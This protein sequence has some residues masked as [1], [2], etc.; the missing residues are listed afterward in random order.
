[1]ALESD[2]YAVLGV[3]RDA[4][5]SQIAK[6]RRRLSRE[7]HPDVNSEPAAS[8]RFV[9]IQ[10]AFALLSDPAARAEYDRTGRLPGRGPGARGQEAA[11]GI[12]VEPASVDFGVLELGRPGTDAEVTVSWT[13][14]SPARIKSGSGND[15]WTTLR[16]A[17]PDAS[18]VVFFLRA[19]AV[20]G[21]AN[22][23]QRDQFTVT[24]DDTT[25]AVGLTAEIQGVPPPPPPPV[26]ETAGQVP[27]PRR[28]APARRR[29]SAGPAIL[30]LITLSFT[31]IWALII[32]QGGGSSGAPSAPTTPTVKPVKVPQ[33]RAPAL[34]VRPVFHDIA[35]D[36]DPL[37]GIVGAPVQHG[38]EILVPLFYSS[39][40]PQPSYCV[41][42]TV[43][44]TDPG[45]DEGLT[46]MESPVGTVTVRGTKELAY[47]AVIPGTYALDAYCDPYDN[48]P[49][50]LVLGFAATPDL[51]VVSGFL[52]NAMVV[53]DAHTTGDVTTVTYGVVGGND[54]GTL[55]PPADDACIDGG[56]A[57]DIATYWQPVRD[58]V[59]QQVNG[60]QEWFSTGS[61]V[62]RD[63]Q[64]PGPQGRFYY[65]CAQDTSEYPLG[66]MVP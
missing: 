18:C 1:M 63:R 54:Y 5:A 45:P 59:S 31:L 39:P 48:A 34:A 36:A 6:A 51:G 24:L 60:K 11:P 17:M 13:G 41:D 28:P 56:G 66:I 46:F 3:P 49:N 20:A 47:P 14:P 4:T 64:G 27:A 61:L 30:S 12:F 38:F 43:P 16:A 35:T 58:L 22:G 26:F 23:R 15:W 52:N 19:Q 37:D 42:V 55:N 57:P 44:D 50:S 33:A 10:Q 40:G 29:G 8:S 53:F 21:A 62:F 32:S 65:S 7:Y 9:E 25:V 2:P